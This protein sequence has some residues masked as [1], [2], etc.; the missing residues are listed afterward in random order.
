MLYII[1][2]SI[3]PSLRPS[4]ITLVHDVKASERILWRGLDWLLRCV[5]CSS[6]FL[7]IAWLTF[8]W[9]AMYSCIYVCVKERQRGG[10]LRYLLLQSPQGESRT[11]LWSFLVSKWDSL[12]LPLHFLS[13]QGSMRRSPTPL[14]G[15]TSPLCFVTHIMTFS[16]TRLRWQ[17]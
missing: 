5:V 7:E 9:A 11:A 14:A 13:Q 16:Q 12:C 8:K 17:L 15:N 6:C 4:S 3:C 10:N 1:V 2:P